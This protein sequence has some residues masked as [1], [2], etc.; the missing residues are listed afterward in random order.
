MKVFLSTL[1]FIP[2]FL[3]LAQT[4]F[5][6]SSQAEFD[7]AHDNASNGDMILWESGTYADVFMEIS[8]EGIIVTAETPGNVIFNGSSR[9]EIE[10]DNVTLSQLQFIG[11]DI[12]DQQEHVI[13]VNADNV[14]CTQLNI[15]EYQCYKYLNVSGDSQRAT[16]SYC[17]FENRPNL[18]DQN[19]LSIRVGSDPGYHKVQYCSFK[20]F[21]GAGSGDAGVEAIRIGVSAEAMLNSRSTVEYCYFTNCNGDD[22]IISSKASQNVYRY[23]TFDGNPESELVLRHGNQA[24]V[25][26]NFFLNGMGGVRVREGSDHFIYNN[27][28]QG[29]DTRAIFLQN[30]SSDPVSDVNI[31]FNTFVNSGEI[32]LG[33]D[34][35]P[36]P[37]TDV[38]F[39]NNIFALPVDDLFAEPTGNET[40]IQNFTQGSLGIDS[41]NGLIGTDPLLETNSLGFY[42]IGGSSPA[43]DASL[44]GFPEVIDFD[45]VD[46]D[47]EILLDI[48]KQDRPSTTAAKDM[49]CFEYSAET[50]IQPF[51]TLDNTGPSYLRDP[52]PD[53]ASITSSVVG[54]GSLVFDPAG[55]SYEAGTNVRITAV[56]DADEL[57]LGWEGALSGTTN[58]QTLTIEEDIMVTANFTTGN[59]VDAVLG[60][61]SEEAVKLFPNPVIDHFSIQVDLI[62]PS[63]ITLR[64][65]D[66]S[67]KEVLNLSKTTRQSGS[68]T[69]R[70]EVPALDTGIYFLDVIILDKKG[71]EPSHQVYKFIKG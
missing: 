52:D 12:E 62:E 71:S 68:Y 55:G 64:V 34:G 31:Y 59:T 17:H 67:G 36:N 1:L 15:S 58:P 53:M 5:N 50:E 56:A 21:E 19:I 24:I 70:Q 29:L 16:I 44:A 30:E 40:W 26:G 25:Y 2:F 23:N 45:G 47:D 54:N 39:A 22:E 37:P 41:Y 13:R 46:F 6:V 33:G 48:M 42:Q 27:L 57:F 7:N 10:G 8:K 63:D 61:D 28:F 3:C 11:G 69:F 49:G 43:I 35:N 9:V 60:I 14:L 32:D 20:D 51:V 18:I 66:S 38:V 65:V 4:Q